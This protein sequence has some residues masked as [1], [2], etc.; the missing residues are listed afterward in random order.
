MHIAVALNKEVISIWGNTVKDFGMFPYPKSASEKPDENHIVE[1]K[2]L[3]CRPC[4][5]VGFAGCPKGHF[6]CMNL[7]DLDEVANLAAN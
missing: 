6:D 7:I 1:V 3:S 5:K 4:S 2:N